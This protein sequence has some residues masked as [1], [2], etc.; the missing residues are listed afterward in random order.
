[1]PELCRY[2]VWRSSDPTGETGATE[3]T[4]SDIILGPTTSNVPLGSSSLISGT[5]SAPAFSLAN[6]YL[7]F[8][9]IFDLTAPG[10]GNLQDVNY[11]QGPE[12]KI[13]T[14]EFT[15]VTAPPT[16]T[17]KVGMILI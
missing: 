2:R 7:F 8:Q 14:T 17:E 12:A 5:W 4:T 16:S 3:I 15:P 6:E 11:Y 13:T 10:T 9:P 1:M